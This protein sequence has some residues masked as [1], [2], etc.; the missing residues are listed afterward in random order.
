M[1]KGDH[2]HGLKPDTGTHFPAILGATSSNGIGRTAA[3]LPSRGTLARGRARLEASSSNVSMLAYPVLGVQGTSLFPPSPPAPSPPPGHTLSAASPAESLAPRFSR[4][5][6]VDKHAS[7]RLLGGRTGRF[8]ARLLQ[9]IS[10]QIRAGTLP[11]PAGPASLACLPAQGVTGIQDPD[12][13]RAARPALLPP[14]LVSPSPRISTPQ[15]DPSRGEP[16]PAGLVPIIPATRPDSTDIPDS[17]EFAESEHSRRDFLASII[18]SNTEGG[19]MLRPLPPMLIPT[20]T[21]IDPPT[22]KPVEP[23]IPKPVNDIENLADVK[24]YL[25]GE[26]RTIVDPD[27]LFKILKGPFE[28]NWF[29]LKTCLTMGK[30]PGSELA[31]EHE[32]SMILMHKMVAMRKFKWRAFTVLVLRKMKAEVREVASRNEMQRSSEGLEEESF[33][34]NLAKT[35]DSVGSE[36]VTSDVDLSLAGSNT[37]I[38]VKLINT[39][40]PKHFQVPYAPA[41][42][43]DIN[44]YASDYIHKSKTGT[45]FKNNKLTI[46][47]GS[48][49]LL[50]GAHLKQKNEQ[51]EV[52]SLV[53]IRRNL[54]D[55]QW[56]MYKLNLLDHLQERKRELI[57]Y[58]F[59]RAEIEF[60]NFRESV[61]LK[62]LALKESVDLAEERLNF[63]KTRF[64]AKYSADAL[65]TLAS[66]ELYAAHLLEVKIIRLEIKELNLL[67]DNVQNREKIQEKGVLLSSKIAQALTFA[68]EVYATEG[69]VKHIVLGQGAGKKLVNLNKARG[70]KRL[71]KIEYVIQPELYLQS[72]NENV[73]DAIHSLHAFHDSPAYAVFRAGKYLARLAEAAHKIIS[74]PQLSRIQ[75][76]VKLELIGARSVGLKS[77]KAIIEGVGLEGDPRNAMNDVFFREQGGNIASLTSTIISVGAAIAGKYHNKSVPASM[78]A[79]PLTPAARPSPPESPRL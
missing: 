31:P 62:K 41:T 54:D 72:V 77:K 3:S 16:A 67:P 19:R 35:L 71:S 64:E 68:N 44:V 1:P 5:Q 47:P 63:S 28:A 51:M 38:A 8:A 9:P 75:G 14:I 23:L 26:S 78:P 30:W 42:V 65:E 76:F 66:N 21:I 17:Q 27:L 11:D 69:A 60:N 43:F 40:F 25:N 46:I 12:R 6:P 58:K 36:A 24:N 18:M 52:W 73:G 32:R 22:P 74:K 29:K 48:E 70:E 53:K 57:I 7:S 20:N 2:E 45:K 59:T 37:E 13:E 56:E 49:I 15:E 79:V 34:E 33:L 50:T 61:D 55:N 39:E 10:S 4:G